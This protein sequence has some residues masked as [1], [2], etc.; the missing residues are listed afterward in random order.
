M[1]AVYRVFAAAMASGVYLCAMASVT[2]TLDRNQATVG[3]RVQLELQSDGGRSGQPN[4]EVL[5]R[6][7]DILGITNGSRTQIVNGNVTAQRQF[8]VLL[9]PKHEG[10]IRIPA[11][12]WGADHSSEL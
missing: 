2:A 10:V 3:E 5:K 4:I 7:F 9:A 1:N 12:Q 6:D 8:T 11:L